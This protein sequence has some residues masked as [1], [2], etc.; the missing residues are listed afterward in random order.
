MSRRYEIEIEDNEWVNLYLF[1]DGVQM[2]GS[3]Y[4]MEAWEDAEAEAIA[5]GDAWVA[6]AQEPETIH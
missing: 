4:P 2:C 6:E 1:E 5:E 3:M